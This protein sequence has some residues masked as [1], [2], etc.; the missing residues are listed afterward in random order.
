MNTNDIR[1]LLVRTLHTG[2]SYN[3]YVE[4]RLSKQAQDVRIHSHVP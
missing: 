1:S 4:D 3:K 2:F